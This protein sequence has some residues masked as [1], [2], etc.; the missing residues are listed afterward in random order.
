MADFP[1]NPLY[2]DISVIQ[3]A[4]LLGVSCG[5]CRIRSKAAKPSG[6]AMTLYKIA[7]RRPEVLRELAA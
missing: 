5:P 6:A 2:I 1:K 7:E 3:E 4:A